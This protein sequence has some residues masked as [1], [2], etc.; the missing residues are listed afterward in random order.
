MIPRDRRT[1]VSSRLHIRCSE[2]GNRR[3][4]RHAALRQLVLDPLLP[5]PIVPAAERRA[6]IE[7]MQRYDRLGRTAWAGWLGEREPT[8]TSVPVGMRERSPAE[9]SGLATLEGA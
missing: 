4:R 1:G 3:F 7:A 8:G 5:E 6:L 9:A 2:A